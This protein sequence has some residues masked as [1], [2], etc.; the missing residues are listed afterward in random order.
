MANREVT[1]YDIA[2]E[3]NVSPSTVSRALKNN[4]AINKET[5]RKVSQCADKMGY[6]S[7]TFASNL[8]KQRTKTIGIIVPRL[9]SSFMSACMG[10]MEEVA[11]SEGYNVIISQSFEQVIKEA[12]NAKTMFDSRVDG[13]IVS[14]AADTKEISHFKPFFDRDIPVVFFDRVPDQTN[15]V[16]FVIDNFKAAEQIT[17]HL[18]DQGCTYLVHVTMS[19]CAS[20]YVA[21]E[22][23]FLAAVASNAEI[24]Q[25]VFRCE[26]LSLETGREM[27]KQIALMNPLP[28]GL[29]VAND[30][31]A[32][33]CLVGLQDLGFKVPGQILVAGFNNDPITTVVKPNLTTI[34]YPGREAG[35]LTAR[36]LIDHLEG[37]TRIFVA[38][39]VVLNS[40]LIVRESTYKISDTIHFEG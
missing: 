26:D 18:I 5:I 34:D 28:D 23:G 29:F 22:R 33:G 16:T 25:V 9:D 8:R 2:A 37:R 1:I 10:G 20:V 30:M 39:S 40:T 38:S 6:R 11:N 12:Q 21:R 17:R 32:T 19:N 15:N 7:N 31:A 36:S 4:K 3:L 14:L 13:V 35:R 27:A 24:K